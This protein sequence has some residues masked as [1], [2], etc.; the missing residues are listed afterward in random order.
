MD[1]V[2]SSPLYNQ[3]YLDR[4]NR[5]KSQRA[6]MYQQEFERILQ[7]TGKNSGSVLD[8]GCGPGDFLDLFPSNQWEKFGYEVNQECISTLKQKGGI[9]TQIPNEAERFD[10]II[11][12]GTLQHYDR[13]MENLF[14][15]YRWLKP[16]GY[17]VVLA[18]PNA[19]G[20][21]Y[22]LFQDLPPLD[23]P[24]NFVIFSAK[25]LRQCLKNIG[26]TEQTFYYPYIGTPYA[27]PFQDICKFALRFLGLKTKFAFFGNM[28]ECYAKK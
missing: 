23:P 19:G 8:I 4:W 16:G 18:T 9:Q 1:E 17:L 13:P 12:R 14:N 6:I 2:K 26:F 15:S 25:I 3:N 11:M 22:R 24:C 27:K 21:V 7:I 28:M 20:I 10:L 5:A